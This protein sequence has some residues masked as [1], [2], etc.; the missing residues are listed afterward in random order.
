MSTSTVF[1]LF[2][3]LVGQGELKNSYDL[4]STPDIS[5]AIQAAAVLDPT[6]IKTANPFIT[7]FLIDDS[8]SIR[9]AGNS[10][11]VAQGCNHLMDSLCKAESAPGILMRAGYL[12]GGQLFPFLPLV[13]LD[14][15]ASAAQNRP[16]YVQNPHMP[17]LRTGKYDPTGEYAT[18]QN[19]V[20]YNPNGYTPLYD[21]T[22]VEAG[23]LMAEFSKFQLANR[24]ARG[25]LLIIGDGHD[26]GS[27]NS[28]DDCRAVVSDLFTLEILVI[29]AMGISDAPKQCRNC[30]TPLAGVVATNVKQCPKCAV[31][32]RQTDFF[33]IF[34]D[35]GIPTQN[36]KVTSS[37]SKEIRATLGAV[38]QHW[39]RLSQVQSQTAFSQAAS[40]GFTI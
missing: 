5:N 7:S 3:N 36:I 16:V 30:G 26:E 21:R 40:G 8:S 29:F 32:F 2:D 11:S 1:D 15:V 25:G 28:I 24:R 35:M 20:M 9:M 14:Q 4:L 34:E 13:N 38:S 39:S 22:I 17:R 12:N 37:D 23:A 6:Q 27:N 10:D 33:K 18:G 19:I 31:G